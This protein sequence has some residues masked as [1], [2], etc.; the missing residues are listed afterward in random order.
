MIAANVPP[1][2]QRLL[3]GLARWSGQSLHDMQRVLAGKERK[4]PSGAQ[5]RAVTKALAPAKAC[6]KLLEAPHKDFGGESIKFCVADVKLLLRYLA[7]QCPS[8]KTFLA[9]GSLPLGVVLSH[10]ETT[11]GNVLATDP[12]QK[13]MMMYLTF[14]GLQ[15]IHESPRA[16]IPLASCSHEQISRIQGG[17]GKVHTLILEDWSKQGLE[18]NFEIADNVHVTLDIVAFCADMDAQRAALEA[19]GSAGLRPCAFCSNCISSYSDAANKDPSFHTIA[20][21][22]FAKFKQYTQKD[23]EAYMR[24]ARQKWPTWTKKQQEMTERCLGFNVT[25]HGMWQSEAACALLPISKYVNDSMHLYYAN[26]IACQEICLLVA[27]VK[28]CTQQ[29]VTDMH[30]AV[31]ETGWQRSG[32]ATRNGQNKYW[33][34]RL[35]HESFFEGAVYKGSAKQAMALISLLRWLV[36]GVWLHHPQL[37]YQA[38]SFQKLCVCLDTLKSISRTRAFDALTAAQEEHMDAFKQAYQD[39]FR[40][41]HH[42]A[43]HLGAQY[44]AT[45]CIPN[46]WGTESKHQDYKKNFAAALQHR[47]T[48]VKGGSEFSESLMCRLLTRHIELLNDNPIAAH[49]YELLKKYT[50]TE[51]LR[52][53]GLDNCEMSSQCHAGMLELAQGDILLWGNNACNAGRCHFFISKHNEL[54]LYMTICEKTNES[55]ALRKFRVT[56]RKQMIKWK[57]LHAPCVPSWWKQINEHLQCLP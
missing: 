29:T 17:M 32:M 50:S 54:F 2:R 40:P 49:G 5:N 36:E 26:G 10:D 11:G 19:K 8:F 38:I 27:A 57:N 20:E 4:R 35:F 43:L 1:K 9:T 46:C 18:Q 56:D 45:Q 23:L 47:L 7:Q 55:A 24:L 6:Y 39:S 21:K 14:V 31:L 48:Q 25:S 12:R 52:V 15:A 22:D 3:S 42:H 28:K 16:W 30:A 37:R 33:T 13:I 41:K 53:A 51:V 44:A 34:K